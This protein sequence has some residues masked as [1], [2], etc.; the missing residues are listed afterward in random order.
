MS[1]SSSRGAHGE[2]LPVLWM[3]LSDSLVHNAEIN[4]C[5]EAMCWFPIAGAYDSRN[6][7]AT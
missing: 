5:H 3:S 6:V 7:D 1:D 4:F 2:T